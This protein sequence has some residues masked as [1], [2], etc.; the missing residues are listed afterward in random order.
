MT[1]NWLHGCIYCMAAHTTIFQMKGVPADIV[2]ALRENTPIADEKLEHCVH[3]RKQSTLAMAGQK[4]V[5]CRLSWQQDTPGKTCLMLSW[6]QASKSCRTIPTMLLTRQLARTS[7]NAMQTTAKVP[8]MPP[9]NGAL[10]RN[11]LPM[12]EASEV[13]VAFQIADVASRFEN[14]RYPANSYENNDSVQH[15]GI[16]AQSAAIQA[17]ASFNLA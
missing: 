17:F 7:S 1:N 5:T 3:L 16:F 11:S 8:T 14:A 6:A 12:M 13:T 4:K 15:Q 2:T 10:M 9:S